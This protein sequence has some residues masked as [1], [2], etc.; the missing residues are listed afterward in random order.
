MPT[1]KR[2]NPDHDTPPK[3]SEK[4]N[5]KEDVICIICDSIVL[6]DNEDDEEQIGDEVIFCEDPCQGWLHRKCAGL[7]NTF[8]KKFTGTNRK[9]LCVFRQ[10]FEQVTLVEELREDVNNL[11]AKL[12]GAPPGSVITNHV[13]FI[14]MS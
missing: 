7:S 6:E 1:K 14:S 9:F 5:K 4:K 10:L 13:S 11:K 8:F 12:A 2:G 3:V